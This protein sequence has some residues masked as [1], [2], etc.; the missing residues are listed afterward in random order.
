MNKINQ[1]ELGT[2]HECTVDLSITIKKTKQYIVLSPFFSLWVKIDSYVL[3]FPLGRKNLCHRNGVENAN[4]CT[5]S[6]VYPRGR[7]P[8]QPGE[9]LTKGRGSLPIKTNP[10]GQVLCKEKSC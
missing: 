4:A 9:Y 10:L 8:G 2:R 3:M 1:F 5:L 6:S 7:T